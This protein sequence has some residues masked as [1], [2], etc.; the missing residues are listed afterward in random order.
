MPFTIRLYQPSDLPRLREITVEAFDGVSI[1]QNAE[2]QFG[3]IHGRDWRWRKARHTDEDA[4][5]DPDGIFVMV[6]GEEILGFIATWM[7][8]EAGIGH[9]PNL[10]L[11]AKA[12]GK[13][14][15]KRLIRKALDHFRRQGLPYAKIETL[16]QNSVGE[17]LYP[18]MGFREVARQIHY[19]MPL[20]ETDNE[21]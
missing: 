13:G 9:I 20:E 11:T 16:A 5:R 4:R 19:L 15:G 17:R 14:L 1:D 12:R 18:A 21:A 10:A 2:R 8:H 7:D 6:D 3:L